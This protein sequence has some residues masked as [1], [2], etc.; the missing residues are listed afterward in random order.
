MDDNFNIRR[1]IARLN[2]YHVKMIET[3]RA[4]GVSAKYAG[5]GGAI[6]GVCESDKD[7]QRLKIRLGEVGCQMVR[8]LIV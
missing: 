7:F 8:P 2:P 5:S 4:C 3:A 6:V 1:S